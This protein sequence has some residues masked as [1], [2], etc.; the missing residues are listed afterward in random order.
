MVKIVER[1]FCRIQNLHISQ[2]CLLFSVRVDMFCRIQNLHISQTASQ[3]AA[4]SV[5]FCRIQNL[6]ISQTNSLAS[7]SPA[8]FVEFKIYIS[9]KHNCFL[10]IFKNVLQNSKFTYLSNGWSV[11]LIK[12]P[13]LQNSKFTYLS[14]INPLQMSQL[15]FCRIQNLHISQTNTKKLCTGIS[16]VEF[17][18]YISLKHSLIV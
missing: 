18:I 9:L 2:T 1:Q 7:P 5:Q 11:K 6:H 10:V 4:C 17:K 13:V 8:C 3:A 14:N 15:Q 12:L 16:F